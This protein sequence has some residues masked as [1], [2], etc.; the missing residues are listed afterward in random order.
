MLTVSGLVES[1][2]KHLNEPEATVRQKVRN[3]QDQG[4][5]PLASGRYVPSITAKDAALAIIG[6]AG[7]SSIKDASKCANLYSRLSIFKPFA[8]YQHQNP[9]QN[10]NAGQFLERVLTSLGSSESQIF[11]LHADATYEF[12]LSWPEI[13][14]SIPVWKGEER[15]ANFEF[16][17]TTAEH[18]GTHWRS[19]VK[20]S[21]SINGIA[22]A[23]VAAELGIGDGEEGEEVG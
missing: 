6:V 7:S 9:L 18:N 22:L 23:S 19:R 12:C 16:R 1:L 21:M 14:A 17:F 10:L 15:Q 8:E 5:L 3:L 13:F 11:F 2:V 20:R 4:L